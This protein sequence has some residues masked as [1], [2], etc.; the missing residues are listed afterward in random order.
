M[1]VD[2]MVKSLMTAKR[3][4]LDKLNQQKQILNWTRES[5]REVNSKLYDFRSNKLITQYGVNEAL[6]SNKAV[7]T[8]N[9]DAVKATALANA[10]GIDMEI[11][12]SQLATKTTVQTAGAGTGFTTSSTLAQLQA[13]LD[14]SDPKSDAAKA[15]EYKLKVNDRTFTFTGATNI[16]TVIATINADTKANVAATFDEITGKLTIASKKSGLDGLVTLGSGANDTS[17]LILFNKKD[18]VDLWESTPGDNA[19]V[20][21]NGTDMTP[22]SNTFTVNGIQL[23]LISKTNLGGSDVKTKITTQIDTDKTM[24]TI[25]GFISDYNTLLTS[26]TSKIGEVKYRDFTPLTDEQKKEMKDDDI[27]AWTEK[28][29]SGLLKNDD[30]LSNLTSS[31]RSIISEKLGGLS[32]IGV[33]TGLYYEGGKLVL[34]ETKLKEAI[35]ANPQKIIDIFQGSTSDPNAGLFDKL[36]DKVTIALNKLSERAGTDKFSAS[37]TSSFKAE[38]VMGKKLVE[39]NSRINT[40]LTM[41]EN[42]E[43]RYYKQFSAME[44]AMNKLQSQSSSLFSTSS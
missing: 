22:S 40:M 24:E 21:I 1:D 7:T 5:Y 28:A 15:K 44:T 25:K 38:S 32:S 8:G 37:T 23:T 4:P 35:T 3:A 17:L 20:N 26:L 16:S 12:V 2:S 43:T 36:A 18:E 29:K 10:S 11:S 31:M 27:T 33:T 34:N 9:T 6:N 42:T 13:P 14:A 39:Y 41:L 19:K 30:I